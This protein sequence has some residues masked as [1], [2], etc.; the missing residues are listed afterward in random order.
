MSQKWALITGASSGIGSA[1]ATRLSK[2]GYNLILTGRRQTRLGEL[3][4]NI[5]KSNPETQIKLAQFDLLKTNEIEQFFRKFDSDLKNVS[6]LINNAGLAM[7]VDKVDQ[8]KLS[9]WDVMLY[10]NV[11]SLM[12]MT[13]GV[14]PYLLAQKS[15]HIVNMGSA[16]G[17]WTY[18]GGAVYCATKFAVRSFSEGLRMDLMGKNIRVSNIEPGMVNTEFSLVRTG[19]QEKA[20][21]IYKN[22]K[23]L[24]AEDIAETIAWVLAQPSHVNIQEMVIYPTAQAHVGMVHRGI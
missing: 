16:A 21:E 17:R 3:E 14:L 19:S 22:M 6:V 8:A 18:P 23:P 24:T 12:H 13:R 15:G 7:G 20:D 9:D 5:K 10:T 2:D 1:T 11:R 4:Q